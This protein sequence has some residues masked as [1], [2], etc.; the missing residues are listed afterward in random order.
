L[1]WNPGAERLFGYSAAEALGRPIDLIIPP[2]RVEEARDMM[3]K[4]QQ[5]Q[6]TLRRETVR[7]HKDGSRRF[8]S[9]SN[10]AIKDAD[11]RPIGIGGIAHDITPLKLAEAARLETEDHLKLAQEAAGL[12]IWDWS[13]PN[14]SITRSEQCCRIYRIACE[15]DDHVLC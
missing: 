4:A 3:R 15:S 7:L 1:T 14:S 6:P 11:G 13:V 2:D 9:L 8:V 12:G 10:F 5:G